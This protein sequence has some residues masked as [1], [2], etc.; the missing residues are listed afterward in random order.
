MSAGRHGTADVL[1]VL[2]NTA[3][4]AGFTEEQLEMVPKV[5]RRCEFGTNETIVA[6]DDSGPGS[7]WLILE[8]SVAVRTGGATIHSLGR[9]DHF[10]E[11]ALLAEE[12]RSAD[13]VT[14]EPTVALELTRSHLLGLVSST[15]EI[16]IGMLAELARRLRR[17]TEVLHGVLD[18]SPDAA[19]AAAELG[20][21]P[22]PLDPVGRDPIVFAL[23]SA[24]QERDAGGR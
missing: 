24:E 1:E 20:V 5:A 4:F 2:R 13:V 16:A 7:L 3:L 22:E 9:G 6:E 10:G 15:P 19:R 12:P 17:T 14:T 18:A 21:E 23:R 11:M 8:G